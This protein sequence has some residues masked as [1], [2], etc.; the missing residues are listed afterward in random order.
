MAIFLPSAVVGA[1]SGNVGGAC[2]VNKS[3]S[4]VV[5]KKRRT[6][7]IT[8]QVHL[9]NQARFANVTREWQA[10]HPIIQDAWNTYGKATPLTN[11]LGT[12]YTLSGFHSFTKI[13]LF[14]QGKIG[15]AGVEPPAIGDDP[16][17]APISVTSNVGV[18]IRVRV[19]IGPVSGQIKMAFYGRLLYT[20]FKPAFFGS[21]RL[22]GVLKVNQDTVTSIT[23]KWQTVFP[24]PVQ[25][26]IIVVMV[27]PYSAAHVFK[28]ETTNIIE[29]F[30]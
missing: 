2:F 14:L 15:F 17:I 3:G 8:S 10:L 28:N 5:R 24:L 21:L 22:F 26:Q 6:N 9:L 25:N 11:R 27:R 18:G 4:L 16:T 13:H 20:T 29:T 30:A 19:G 12:P 23:S 1:I 7:S